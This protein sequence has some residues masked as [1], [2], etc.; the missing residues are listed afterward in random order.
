VTLTFAE[1]DRAFS[2]DL[3][4]KLLPSGSYVVDILRVTSKTL[5]RVKSQKDYSG[6]GRGRVERRV[7]WSKG[8]VELAEVAK[9]NH[10]PYSSYK[11]VMDWS[12]FRVAQFFEIRRDTR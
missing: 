3:L 7:G 11:T 1:G 4:R 2:R 12:L 5:V 6:V 8:G 9:E 10:T